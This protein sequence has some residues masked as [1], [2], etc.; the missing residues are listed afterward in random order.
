[1]KIICAVLLLAGAPFAFAADRPDPTYER[2]LI[3]V[4]ISGPGAQGAQ[5]ETAVS[6]TSTAERVFLLARPVLL[7][8]HDLFCDPGCA[9]RVFHPDVAVRV[10]RTLEH[11]AGLILWVPRAMAWSDFNASVRVRDAARNATSAGT[12]VPLVREDDL[13]GHKMVLLDVPVREGFRAS[14][15]LYDL[16]LS[17][18]TAEVEIYDME[19]YRSGESGSEPLVHAF[20]ALESDAPASNEDVQFQQR[21]AFAFIGDLRAAYPQLAN[22]ESVAIV[23]TGLHPIISPPAYDKRFYALSSV[24]NDATNEVTIIAPR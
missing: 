17:A 23:V 24:T 1:M 21:P 20:V 3:P 5:W 19:D 22:V 4:F 9:D 8:E 2:V 18:T 13:T 6:L 15:R 12:L 11:P 16:Y 7:Y 10:A 14:L